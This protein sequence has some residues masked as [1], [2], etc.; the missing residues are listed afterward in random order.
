MYRRAPVESA[1]RN[2]DDRQQI[3]CHPDSLS[4]NGR[5][6]RQLHRLRC[7]D[8]KVTPQQGKRVASGLTL[9][10]HRQFDAEAVAK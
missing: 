6:F 2:R 7:V 5:A 3:T 1:T 4:S 10:M 9:E 8:L